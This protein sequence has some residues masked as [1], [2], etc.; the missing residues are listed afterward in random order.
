MSTKKTTVAAQIAAVAGAEQ[1]TAAIDESASRD[2][3]LNRDDVVT[4]ELTDLV[5]DSNGEIVLFNDSHLPALA[6]RADRLP[7]ASGEMGSHVTAAGDDV[8]GYRFVAFDNGTK[9]IFQDS[10]DLVILGTQGEVH[11]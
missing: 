3:G 10:V 11:V 5:S 9:L 2:A 7:V 4:L 6:V 8:T 1:Q